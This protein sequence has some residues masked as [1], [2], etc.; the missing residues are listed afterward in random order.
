[1]RPL[2]VGRVESA[3]HPAMAHYGDIPT[4]CKEI[5]TKRFFTKGGQGGQG[6]AIGDEVASAIVV[7]GSRASIPRIVQ[8]K[9]KLRQNLIKLVQA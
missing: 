6:S 3:F 4:S 9:S 5:S 7:V 2:S 8:A 1:M